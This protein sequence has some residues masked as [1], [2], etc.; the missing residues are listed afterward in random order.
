M[1]SSRRRSSVAGRARSTSGHHAVA[2][3]PWRRPVYALAPPR[4]CPGA[5]LYM[6]WRRH[7]RAL[8]PPCTWR[9]GLALSRACQ[10]TCSGAALVTGASL[11]AHLSR[12]QGRRELGKV[13]RPWLRACSG[14]GVLPSAGAAVRRLPAAATPPGAA[15]AAGR[16]KGEPR[17][18]ETAQ[19]SIRSAL[20]HSGHPSGRHS[21]RHDRMVGVSDPSVPTS[22][23]AWRAAVGS[24]RRRSSTRDTESVI[25]VSHGRRRMD[26]LS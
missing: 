13:K 9:R 23:A 4:T 21:G 14:A 6:P 25:V 11:K 22:T 1:G 20:C 7:A 8:A 26:V 10:G 5:A 16:A 15:P 3:V 19:H 2:Q 18:A 17:S 12:R 24:R